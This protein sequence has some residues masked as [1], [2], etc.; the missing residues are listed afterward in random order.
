VSPPD[1]AERRV[2]VVTG[3]GTGIGRASALALAKAGWAVVVA[4]R[5]QPPLDE[6][7]ATA[8]ADG[9]TV[10]GV[11]VN[12]SDPASVDALFAT[13][14][15]RLGRVDLLFNNAG[16]G[17]LDTAFHDLSYED[18]SATMAT[19]VTGTFLCAQRAIAQMIAQTPRGGRIINNGSVSAQTPRPQ[20]AA[21]TASKHAVTGLTKSIALDY[22][23]SDI[24]CGQID[25]GNART[26]LAVEE[27]I[28]TGMRQAN[29]E[30][31]TEPLIDADHVA[32]TVMYMASL[33]LDVNVLFITVMAAQMPF[34]GRG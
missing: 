21:Y 34:V 28:G 8:E 31:L 16:I 33:P 30:T 14:I 4:G 12:V 25:I 18:W 23:S 17:L 24:A 22:R 15:D 26:D 2:A 20:A 5:R 6:V 27:G 19:N 13:T 11:P 9:S 7:A 1:Q 3:G 10:L 32:S 29:G